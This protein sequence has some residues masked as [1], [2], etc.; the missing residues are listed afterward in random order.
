MVPPWARFIFLG[1]VQG[2][3]PATKCARPRSFGF[4]VLV[5]LGMPKWRC[6]LLVYGWKPPAHVLREIL[7]RGVHLQASPSEQMVFAMI[8]RADLE[9]DVGEGLH[10]YQGM[11][12]LRIHV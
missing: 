6:E 9:N 10:A 2:A 7:M 1:A 5:A 4:V 12:L 3:R 11:L 8:V